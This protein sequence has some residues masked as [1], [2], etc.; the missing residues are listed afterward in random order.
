MHGILLLHTSSN[1]RTSGPIKDRKFLGFVSVYP[2]LDRIC[3]PWSW[4]TNVLWKSHEVLTAEDTARLFFYPLVFWNTKYAKSR[5]EGPVILSRI[6]PPPP[7]FYSPWRTT[8]HRKTRTNIHALSRIRTHDPSNQPA[9]THASDRT[10][11]VTGNLS[12]ISGA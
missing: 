7:W 6:S 9:K 11:T 2:F 12:G 1:H 10:A 3:V 4:L 5:P 8:Q